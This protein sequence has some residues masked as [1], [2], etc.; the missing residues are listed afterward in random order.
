MSNFIKLEFISTVQFNGGKTEK[1]IEEQW[2]NLDYVTNYHPKR[3]CIF[4]SGDDHSFMNLTEK[5]CKDLEAQLGIK[6]D[7]E[8][9]EKLIDLLDEF[10]FDDDDCSYDHHG[11]CQ[12]H[13]L[14]EAP[15][16]HTRA[17]EI[18][19]KWKKDKTL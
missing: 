11:Y 7:S 9:I 19:N 4:F 15:C 1:V 16:E 8:D 14:G 12:A 2:I 6:A 5:G 10:V 17:K 13:G 18:I 3:M